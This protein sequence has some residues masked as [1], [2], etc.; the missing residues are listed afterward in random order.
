MA[1]QLAPFMKKYDTVLFDMDG[2]ITSEESYWNIAAMTVVEQ[3]HSKHYFGAEEIDTKYYMA[4]IRD[5]RET[6]FCNDRTIK[7]VKN[8]GVN[9]NWDLAYLV[10]G[11]AL[12]LGT[13][14]DFEAVYAY[15]KAL[16]EDVFQMYDHIGHE[17][18]RILKKPFSHTERLGPFWTGVTY[19][20]QEWFLGDDLFPEVWGVDCVQTG[21]S[22]LMFAEQPIVDKDRLITLF[23]LLNEAGMRVGIGTGR[24]RVEAVGVLK[25]WDALRFFAPDAVIDYTHVTDAESHLR[26]L[27]QDTALTKPHPY[28]FLKG[29]FGS[30]YPDEKIAAGVYD[31]K[32]CATVLVVGDAGADLY[33]AFA[34]GCDFAAVLTGIQ[35]Q[36][37]R[38]FFER[39]HATYILNDVLELMTETET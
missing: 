27:G 24:P 20:F 25:Q 4:H 6:V 14:T 15:L 23:R 18:A 17:L 29:I 37:A 33:A 8:R 34:A 5:M 13:D 21:K 9:S 19:C 39:E 10:L 1:Y 38:P 26:S 36:E 3:L 16:D 35:K 28:M 2:V 31:K 11:A 30:G 32:R 12:I 22:G 7:L